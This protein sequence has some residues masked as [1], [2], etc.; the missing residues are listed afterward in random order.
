MVANGRGPALAIRGAAVLLLRHQVSAFPVADQEN[1]ALLGI[2]SELDPLKGHLPADP[3]G[4]LRTPRQDSGPPI[5]RCVSD[6]MTRDVAT[7]SVTSDGA[8]LAAVMLARRFKSLPVVD[9]GRVVGIVSRRD[10]LRT[11]V[12]DDDA[13]ATEVVDRLGRAHIEADWQVLC[14]D[15][16]VTLTGPDGDQQRKVAL[17]V[18]RTVPGAIR[19]DFVSMSAGGH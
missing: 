15:G 2:V 8:H 6:V 4:Q 14:Q 7:V 10:L 5:P 19:V 11:L 9:G 1:G 13:V 3:R 12:R 18:A 16:V 17:A